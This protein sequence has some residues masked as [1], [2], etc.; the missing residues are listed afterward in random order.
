[1]EVTFYRLF[2]SYSF[3]MTYELD[4]YIFS[5]DIAAHHGFQYDFIGAPV[6]EGYMEATP[7]AAFLPILN[8]GFSIRRISSCLTA[9]QSLRQYRWRWKWQQFLL[10]RFRFLRAWFSPA[11]VQAVLDDHLKGYFKGGYFHED[12]IWTFVVPALFPFFRTAPPEVAARFS[13]EVNA[14]RLFRLNRQQLPL[15]CH[16]WARFPDFWKDHI[17]AAAVLPGLKHNDR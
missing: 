14:A 1:M 10:S 12:M 13:F 15:G 11:T 7:D 4:A 6:F 9:L 8:S 5:A 2:A 17:P 3:M 16:A